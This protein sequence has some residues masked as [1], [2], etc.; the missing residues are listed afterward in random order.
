MCFGAKKND[1]VIKSVRLDDQLVY[2]YTIYA[3]KQ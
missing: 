2:W 3:E 1:A